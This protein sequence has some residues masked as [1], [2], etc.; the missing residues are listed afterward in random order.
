MA[1]KGYCRPGRRG[2]SSKF[3]IL[4]ARQVQR[5]FSMFPAGLPGSALLLLRIT[6]AGLLLVS[7][8]SNESTG[9]VTPLKLLALSITCILLCLGALTPL[10]SVLSLVIQAMYF[11]SLDGLRSAS[12]ALHM[13]VSVAVFLLGPGAYSLD[14]KMFG[15]RLILPAPK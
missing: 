14:S 10:A 15:R 4:Y 7:S 2:Q 13:C 5:L 8:L 1:R 3:H 9:S 12:L 11:P 6:V